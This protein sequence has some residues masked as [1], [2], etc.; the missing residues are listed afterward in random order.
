M[1]VFFHK[2]PIVGIDLGTVNTIVFIEGKG[3]VFNEPSIV[4]RHIRTGDIIAVGNEAIKMIEGSAKAADYIVTS[5]PIKDGVITDFE[6]TEA[7]LKYILKKSVKFT[8][9]K[10]SLLLC[11]PGKMSSIEK[12]VI[13]KAAKQAGANDIFFIQEAVAAAFGSG[14]SPNEASGHMIVDIGGGTTELAIISLGTIVSG[15]SAKIGG[16]MIDQALI[17]Y[18]LKDHELMISDRT[19][20]MA[21]LKTTGTSQNDENRLE[22]K[23]RDSRTGLI[24][25]VIIQNNDVT[26]LIHPMIETI[27]KRIKHV[28]AEAPPEISGDL[29]QNGIILTGGGALLNNIGTLIADEIKV[30]VTIAADPL[31][32]VIL[33]TGDRLKDMKKMKKHDRRK[34]RGDY[35]KEMSV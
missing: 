31:N 30:P 27:N 33:G 18:L 9:R 34:K 2:A 15:E 35:G 22:I 28:L 7:I 20:E 16:D 3:I 32:S 6:T 5:R 23:G 14:L 26:K 24:K 25:S 19:A 4:A 17:A 29:L 13:T 12:K 21:K 8:L 1:A 10:P 11:A